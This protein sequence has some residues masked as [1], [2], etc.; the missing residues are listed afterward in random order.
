MEPPGRCGDWLAPPPSP[1]RGQAPGRHDE[2]G[3]ETSNRPPTGTYTWPSA[4]TFPWP[5]TPLHLLEVQVGG[6]GRG[7]SVPAIT[8]VV[9]S[10]WAGCG[11][12]T[13]SWFMPVALSARRLVGR[14]SV[15]SV[16]AWGSSTTRCR[17]VRAVAAGFGALRV[18]FG[19]GVC[20]ASPPP[21]APPAGPA[22]VIISC[23]PASGCG[24]RGLDTAGPLPTG[25]ADRSMSVRQAERN[26]RGELGDIGIPARRD[27]LGD[28]DGHTKPMTS[29]GWLVL[30]VRAGLS[31]AGV[32]GVYHRQ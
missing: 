13:S 8:G 12:G 4:G 20:N 19:G 10:F 7:C 1:P 32:R 15:G 28:R 21:G 29:P 11:G 24:C 2:R 25:R 18:W 14:V 27:L 23:G 30:G 5:W 16:R 17:V 26:V 22:A 31:C 6:V 3:V 9:P